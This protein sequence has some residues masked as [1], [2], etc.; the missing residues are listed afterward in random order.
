MAIKHKIRNN[1]DGSEQTVNLTP[2]KAIRKICLEGRT[3]YCSELSSYKED[4][5]TNEMS[6]KKAQILL[7]IDFES[8]EI[9]KE[10]SFICATDQQQS[11]LESIC[12]VMLASL[13]ADEV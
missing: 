1:C 6:D 5:V 10:A 12:T 8:S 2:T 9:L 4:G 11:Q 7:D 3:E 13:R